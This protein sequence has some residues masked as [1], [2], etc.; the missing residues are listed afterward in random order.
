MGRIGAVSELIIGP[1]E[2]CGLLDRIEAVEEGPERSSP[3]WVMWV[4]SSP[5]LRRGFGVSTAKRR[6][7]TGE[8]Q[9]TF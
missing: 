8:Q 1:R 6:T 5:G 7:V 4:D 2:P 3:A 9:L